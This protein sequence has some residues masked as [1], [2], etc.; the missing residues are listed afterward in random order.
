MNTDIDRE[1]N[2]INDVNPGPDLSPG[3]GN[4]RLDFLE[5]VYGVLFD[6]V[7]TMEIVA[8]RPPVG[9]AFLVFTILSASSVTV[10]MLAASQTLT[11][12]LY[13]SGMER[14]LPVSRTL[15]PLGV[16]F[17]LFW[18]YVKW[19]GYSAVIHLAAELLDGKGAAAG[20]FAVV[21][22]AGLPTVFMVPAHLLSYWL[23]TGGLIIIIL[24]G[25]AT[26]IWSAVLLVIGLKRV[27]GLTTG[28][29]VL[30]VLSPFMVFLAL[31]IIM[32]AALVAVAASLPAGMDGTRFF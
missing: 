20:V 16:I 24:A 19:F 21:G 7:R 1:S 25:L 4:S 11:T 12:G 14:L 17:G 13:G 3:G 31:M 8:K 2:E 28:R 10:W 18:G 27:H 6:P 9:L 23:G 15:I 26:G 30:V 5:L 32:I 22:L 29:S